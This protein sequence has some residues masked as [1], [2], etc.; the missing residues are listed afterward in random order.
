MSH[1]HIA[2]I[3]ASVF[4][5]IACTSVQADSTKPGK[6]P[7]SRVT[8]EGAIFDSRTWMYDE[9]NQRVR[10][11]P[12]YR[13]WSAQDRQKVL[14]PKNPGDVWYSGNR[15][16][17]LGV[18]RW[19]SPGEL[20][21]L[22][23]YEQQRLSQINDRTAGTGSTTQHVTQVLARTNTQRLKNL[24]I[25]AT[26]RI[27][28]A[29]AIGS[30]V[31]TEIHGRKFVLTANHVIKGANYADLSSL[32]DQSTGT[33]YRTTLWNVKYDIAVLPLPKNLSHLP[34]VKIAFTPPPVGQQVFLS[35]FPKDDYTLT[36]GNVVGFRMNGNEL[37]HNARSTSGASGGMLLTA[38]GKLAG[39]HTGSYT[40]ASSL[41]GYK[42]ATPARLVIE[43]AR[44]YS[45]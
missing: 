33:I 45:R 20:Q 42:S 31:I 39:I 23:Q 25:G 41:S 11:R 17:G 29:E 18:G 9:V 44:R 7:Y 14:Q 5:V 19:V 22:R 1:T 2:N 26:V 21:T 10:I 27:S 43:L 13:G 3:L 12:E 35:G 38:S 15:E 28:T 30:G 32:K 6:A 24:I 16:L 8:P 34:S 40:S 4:I 36:A 37:L